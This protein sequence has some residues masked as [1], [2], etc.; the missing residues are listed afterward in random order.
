MSTE[1]FD[2]SA[3]RYPEPTYGHPDYDAP[4][5]VDDLDD[6]DFTAEHVGLIVPPVEIEASRH[7]R[8][9]V[10]GWGMLSDLSFS[11]LL[12]Y[13]PLP[14]QSESEE[15]RFLVVNQ[16][17]PNTGQT[18]FLDDVVGRTMSATQRPAVA[19][20]ASSAEIVDTV[21]DSAWLGERIRVTAI[22]VRFRD[23]VVAVIASESALS[24]NRQRGVLE[25][26]YLEVF[27]R[28]AAMVSAGIFPFE[29]EEVLAAGGPRVG[30]GVILLDKLG[31]VTFTSPNAISALRR[32]RISGRIQG[33]SL[34]E[35]GVESDTTYR[36]FF[37]GRP[38]AE[39]V[40]RNE[41][42]VVIWCIPLLDGE[43][44]D[45][46]LVLLRD[47]SELKSR[48]RLLISKDATIKEIHHRVKN[49]LQ[50]I[51][52]LLRLQGRRLTEPSAKAAIEESVRRI[53]SI[54][55]VHET[56]SREDGDEVNF[57]EILRP[58]V[59]MVE[60]GL[61]SPDRPL[62]FKMVGE[63]GNLP[64]PTATSLA[65]VL[66]ELLQNVVDHAYPP[67]SLMPDELAQ[68]RIEMLQGGGVLR[69]DV[70]DDGVG[71][72]NDSH[73][74]ST[75]SLGLSIVRGLVSELDGRISFDP[76]D[77]V[78]AAGETRTATGH[79]RR[80]GTRVSLTIPVVRDPVAT[81]PPHGEA[82]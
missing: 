73:P 15:K 54:A 12:L 36:A 74:A 56:L 58:L 51:S 55:L 81:R 76:A 72:G 29:D 77:S 65:V 31:K 64:S 19:E 17:R 40:E 10:A 26:V 32:L 52:S 28:L 70:I 1:A 80:E 5:V 79:L 46:G 35:L 57:S 60:E 53:R 48:D 34:T 41:I 8:R 4:D 21:I 75:P 16:M 30:D 14:V 45:G 13:V 47:I 18:L 7:L 49:N 71:M 24:T 43:R 69:V 42:C 62:S 23:Q 63:S 61:T 25:G 67:G 6:G 38:A 66:T 50:T 11:D 78:A 82:E 68:V 44:V 27:G 3:T 9:L 2:N 20:A 37:T 39:E 59:R 22:P 33:S